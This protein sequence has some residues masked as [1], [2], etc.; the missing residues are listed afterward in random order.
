MSN[1]GQA[2][3]PAPRPGSSMAAPPPQTQ[4]WERPFIY[5]MDFTGTPAIAAGATVNGNIQIQADSRFKWILAAQFS[6]IDGA[7]QLESELVIPN[8]ALQI[9][10]SGTGAQ[11]FQNAV[12]IASFFGNGRLPFVLP[13][14]YIFKPNS[15]LAF[16]LTN[17]GTD[18]YTS[19]RLSL[20]GTKIFEGAPP[21]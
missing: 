13:I 3:T 19:I 15:N 14:P 16:S 1:P 21:A 20:I 17:F 9:V 5:E 12:P 4:F 18:A 2:A 10:D 7:T 8:V 6:T 11:V